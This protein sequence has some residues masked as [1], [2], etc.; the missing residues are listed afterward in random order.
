M[1]QTVN[2][3]SIDVEDYFQAFEMRKMKVGSCEK[4]YRDQGVERILNILNKKDVKATFLVNGFFAERN[5]NLIKLI[6]DFG[7]EIGSH[8]YSHTKIQELS[9]SKFSK[10]LLKSKELL[11][12]IT[13]KKI[14]GY[15]SPAFSFDEKNI[16]YTKALIDNGFQYDSS[17]N[18]ISKF[19]HGHPGYNP[20]FHEVRYEGKSFMEF[21]LATLPIFGVR[22]PWAGGFY[23]RM[24]PY[25][26]FKNGLKYINKK[27]GSGVIY[28]HNWELDPDIPKIKSSKLLHFIHYHGLEKMENKLENL[29]TD[30]KFVPFINFMDHGGTQGKPGAPSQ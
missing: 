15:R 23:L 5:R 18:P 28:L 26:L 30:F 19:L 11:E 7:H 10:E 22:L 12:E 2:I 25:V 4:T 29:L 13:Q 1:S 3:L 27:Y 21:P 6:S 24:M 8:S 20:S 17:T 9:P 14:I 16:Q